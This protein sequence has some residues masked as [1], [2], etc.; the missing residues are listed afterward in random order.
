MTQFTIKA[1]PIGQVW[2]GMRIYGSDKSKEIFKALHD[3]VP[4]NADDTK[5]AIILTDIIAVGGTQ[6]FLVFYFY[7]GPEPPTIGPFAKFL[8]ID[9]A[10]DTASTQSYAKLVRV[11]DVNSQ[12]QKLISCPLV[13]I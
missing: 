11:G 10:L 7:D 6:L 1:Y 2:G 4:G 13:E 3:F 5:A 8:D 12:S 9:S